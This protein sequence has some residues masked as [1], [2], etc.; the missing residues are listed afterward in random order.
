MSQAQA[1]A[2]CTDLSH[3]LEHSGAEDFTV[4]NSDGRLVTE[5]A[6]EVLSRANWL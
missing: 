6:R 4:D 1:L 3:I 2:L 5:V